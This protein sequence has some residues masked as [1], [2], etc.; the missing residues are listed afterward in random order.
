MK[1]MVVGGALLAC[2]T[3]A[4]AISFSYS[5]PPV[6]I[7]D[8][9]DLSGA[10][11]GAQVGAPIAV[12]GFTRPVSKVT[13]SI[14]G[15]ICTAGIGAT[16]VGIDHT[17]VSDLVITLR[18]PD[19][20]E[21]VLANQAD[22]SGN[23]LCQVVFDDAETASLQT[24]PSASAPFTG[25]YG[26]YSPLAAFAGKAGNGTWTLQVQDFFSG[27]TG[28]IRAWTINITEAAP[29]P[30]PAS[31]PTL[32]EWALIGMSSLIALVGLGGVRRCAAA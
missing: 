20:T 4:S 29:V 12:S 32:S 31:I 19:G 26:P 21:V 6:A 13:L 8:A 9:A 16:T 10:S 15:T 24:A 14:D 28:S 11:P 27:D 23:N 25:S 1:Y 22:G 2:S 18:A 7:P 3:W 5:G 17:F 30:A